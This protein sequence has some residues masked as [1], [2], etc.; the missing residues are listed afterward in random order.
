MQKALFLA[1]VVFLAGCVTM[2]DGPA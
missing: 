2:P 1:P